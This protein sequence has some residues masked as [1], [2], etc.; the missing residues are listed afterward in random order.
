MFPFLLDSIE[1]IGTINDGVGIKLF[2]F[3]LDSIETGND[4]D[5]REF[6][7]YVSIPLRFD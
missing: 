7:I 1:T 6:L 4:G 3:L 5:I 2:P